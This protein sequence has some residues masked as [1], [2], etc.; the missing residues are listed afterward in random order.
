MRKF[1]MI[2][3][4][5]ALTFS[6]AYAEKVLYEYDAHGRLVKVQRCGADNV[7]DGDADDVDTDYDYDAAD[8]RTEKKVTVDPPP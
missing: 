4:V 5:I 6:Q 8:N 7:C 2:C 3:S 1:L